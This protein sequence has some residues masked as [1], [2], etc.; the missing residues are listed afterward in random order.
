MNRRA[1]IRPKNAEIPSWAGEN[2]ERTIRQPLKIRAR[3]GNNGKYEVALSEERLKALSE[4]LK[5]DISLEENPDGPHPFWDENPQATL[6][7]DNKTHVFDLDNVYDEIK[8]AIAKA[9]PWV[10]E[11]I[12]EAANNPETMFM[13]YAEEEEAEAKHSRLRVRREANKMADEINHTAKLNVLKIMT[14]RY[15]INA[16]NSVIDLE[17]QN[18]VDN[19]P[20]EF[21]RWCNEDKETLAIRALVLN[22]IDAGDIVRDSGQI[23]YG[24]VFLGVDVGEAVKTITEPDNIA[25]A[26]R[27]SEKLKER[28]H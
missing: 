15:F 10:A 22:A 2:E 24:D 23:R 7:L 6:V 1:E 28:G 17:I 19:E 25:L 3:L 12:E 18:L 14:G 20:E 26:K 11:S 13:V 8:L 21:L 4:K 27:L 5:Y 9:H 16:S